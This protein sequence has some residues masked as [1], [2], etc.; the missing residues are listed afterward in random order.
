MIY[1]I[2]NFEKALKESGEEQQ[3]VTPRG[4]N[5][6]FSVENG[7][8][9]IKWGIYPYDMDR[10]NIP[11]DTDHFNKCGQLYQYTTGLISNKRHDR[12]N[13]SC[14]MF[15]YILRLSAI[16]DIKI[17]SDWSISV[18]NY[19]SKASQFFD[20]NGKPELKNGFEKF[21]SFLKTDLII[22]LGE[23]VKS[24]ETYNEIEKK[25]I[26]L[27]K[28]FI[29][30]DTKE[31]YYKEAQ[32][33]CLQGNPI[34][35]KKS[36][37]QDDMEYHE[38]YKESDLMSGFSAHKEFLLHR[39][40]PFKYDFKIPSSYI[41][42]IN[43]FFTKLSSSFPKPL[44]IFIDKKELNRKVINIFE[45]D[46]KLTFAD[47]FER[48][49]ATNEGIEDGDL[50]NYYLLYAQKIIGGF[51]IKDLEFVPSFNYIL[52]YKI[53]HVF[54][55]VKKL[56]FVINTI[57]DFQRIIIGE[58]FDNCLIKFDE[59]EG[60]FTNNYW[61]EVKEKFCKSTNNFRL[62]LQYR[63]AFYDFVYKS[64]RQAIT[65]RMLNDI[66]L[67]GVV[68]AL[69]DEKFRTKNP[70]KE[71]RIKTLLNIY[72]NLN[73]HFDTNNNNFT[74]INTSMATKT[75]ELISY[76]Q[77]L[78]SNDDKHFE[79]NE[80]VEFAFCFGQLVFYLLSQS[81]ASKKTHSLL[82]TYLQ[83]PDFNLL[84]QKA[85]EDAT[86]YSYRISFHNKKFNK[87]CGEVFGYTPQTKFNDLIS[88]FLAGYFSK[89]IIY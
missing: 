68:D 75:K 24:V 65:G 10:K 35:E 22:K 49:Y 8:E 2:I 37:S 88:F 64:M 32:I 71:E 66:I 4:L 27:D 77:E 83:K 12:K 1:E 57:F 43:D 78:V 38:D 34:S 51:E 80:D 54:D 25:K 17:N 61:G 58:L 3:A 62:I 50:Q 33:N 47:I 86:K 40:A 18:E 29:F 74:K 9:I 11:F 30:F 67:S 82:L 55:T 87:M 63:K 56:P 26:K 31:E 72:F 23:I 53:E 42:I 84:K 79:E 48:I 39:T 19:K 13:E 89:N 45:K 14:S 46:K 20:L 28:V 5:I 60:R 76:A 59:K 73:Q 6:L 41:T 44:P 7:Q 36:E 21:I 52:N 70:A 15:S 69:K 16:E 85:K 81:E